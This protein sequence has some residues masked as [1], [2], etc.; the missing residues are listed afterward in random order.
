MP[1]VHRKGENQPKA[2]GGLCSRQYYTVI[3]FT[4]SIVL[5]NQSGA[6]VLSSHLLH[7]V[8]MG[9]VFGFDSFVQCGTH[10]H[11]DLLAVL[12]TLSRTGS[13]F[14]SGALSKDGSFMDSGTL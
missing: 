8:F 13:L 10:K 11:R 6:M 9:T 3:C 5:L 7:S 12:G 1:L 4:E 2:D 14:R